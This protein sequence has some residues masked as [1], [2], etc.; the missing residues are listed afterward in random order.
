MARLIVGFVEAFAAVISIAFAGVDRLENALARITS[1]INLPL[2]WPRVTF[3]LFP[4]YLLS[5]SASVPCAFNSLFAF[6]TTVSVH[7]HRMDDAKQ[8][9]MDKL[10]A[11]S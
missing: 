4:L 2:Y 6:G 10:E 7:E 3:C 9:L 11:P 5:T 1:P 8:I